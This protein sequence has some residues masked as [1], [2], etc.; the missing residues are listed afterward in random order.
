MEKY[1]RNRIGRNHNQDIF[2]ENKLFSIKENIKTILLKIK[3]MIIC[4]SPT[5]PLS[6]YLEYTK[7]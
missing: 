1:G 4:L 5:S 7:M 6:I 3:K 2:N